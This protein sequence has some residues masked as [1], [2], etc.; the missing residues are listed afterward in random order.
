[1]VDMVPVPQRLE[2]AVGKAQDHDV[3]HRLLAEEMVH[4][5]DLILGQDLR[6]AGIERPRGFKVVAKRLFDDDPAPMLVL[7]AGQAGRREPLDD[8]A[9]QRGRDGK[10]EHDIAGGAVL[11]LRLFERLRETVVHFGIGNIALQM[12]HPRGEKFPGP[13]IEWRGHRTRAGVRDKAADALGQIGAKFLVRP[14]GA[15][16]ADQ[17]EFVREP[18]GLGEIVERRDQQALCQVAARPEDDHRAGRAL[19]GTCRADRRPIE[20]EIHALSFWP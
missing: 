5:V 15:V 1:M 12:G 18:A 2:D 14:V 20:A 17:C 4:P 8:R 19:N 13:R 3:L 9:E 10:V 16:D 11:A 7:F 6:Q